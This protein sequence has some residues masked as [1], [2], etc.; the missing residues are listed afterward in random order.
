MKLAEIIKEIRSLPITDRMYV[1]EKAIRSIRNEENKTSLQL[2]AE[3][4]R[5]DYLTDTE[6]T[7]FSRS[8]L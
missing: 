3:A 8:R 2:A 4:L 1:V 5:S 6:L 7:A